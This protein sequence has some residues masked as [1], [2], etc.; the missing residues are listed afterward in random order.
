MCGVAGSP[1]TSV[2]SP[3]PAHSDRRFELGRGRDRVNPAFVSAEG[4]VMST[5]RSPRSPPLREGTASRSDARSVGQTLQRAFAVSLAFLAVAGTAGFVALILS[6]DRYE[7]VVDHDMPLLLANQQILQSMTDAESAERGFLITGDRAFL[8][9]Y[10]PAKARYRDAVDQASALARSATVRRS[11]RAQAVA[12]Q[13]WIDEFA[14]PTIALGAEDPAAALAVAQAG[15]GRRRFDRLRRL[16]GETETQIRIG[17]D[18]AAARAR[19]ATRAAAAVLGGLVA[20]T[21]VGGALAAKRATRRINAPLAEL[22]ETLRRL[23]NGEDHARV[24]VDGPAEIASVGHA[25][26]TMAT[27]SERLRQLQNGRVEMASTIREVAAAL[28][29][30]LLVEDVLHCAVERVGP[31][32]DQSAIARRLLADSDDVVAAWPAEPN[33]GPSASEAGHYP[34]ALRGLMGSGKPN[35]LLLIDDVA[36]EPALDDDGRQFLMSRG[37]RSAMVAR[38]GDIGAVG[39]V[40][41]VHGSAPRE[42]SDIDTA[43]LEGIAREVRIALANALSFEQ[44]QH[45]VDKL[46]QLDQERSGFISNVSHELRTPLTSIIGYI[47]LL[48]DG[49]AGQLTKD[50]A[51][52]VNTVVRNSHRLLELIEDLLL[53]SR[54]EA[55]T[56]TMDRSP[57]AIGRVVA[58]AVNTLGPQFR[59]RSV[60]LTLYTDVETGDVI[61]D[62]RQLERVMVNLLGNA[63]KFTQPGGTVTVSAAN[64]GEWL[65]IIVADDGIG[66]PVADQPRLF[67]RFFRSSSAQEHAIKGT[68]LGLS[69]TKTIV[70]RHGGTV[71]VESWPGVGSTFRVRLPAASSQQ[72][73]K[74]GPTHHSPT[75]PAPTDSPA[76]T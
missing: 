36:N 68:G 13:A 70:E 52:L 2:D 5:L 15:G 19:S 56:F 62:V 8:E 9:P 22:V 32:F 35:D 48:E 14:E 41:E 33:G 60:D 53:L 43:L 26:N 23:T 69:I 54:M 66:I 67:E 59:A 51:E 47:E 29:S 65:D 31:L 3:P 76:A 40:L 24:R 73:A 11:I 27:E 44:Q 58:D 37:T 21:M 30:R 74:A 39:V 1:A 50:Q 16:N 17:V 25:V 57:V 72:L 10:A 20:V 28:H 34:V 75:P 6:A 71:T 45:V 18:R 42:W 55:G 4:I 46:R 7:S 64:R 61:G 38:L 12:G 63:V 49:G